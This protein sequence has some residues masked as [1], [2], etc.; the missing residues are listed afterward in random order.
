MI[1]APGADPDSLG[2]DKVTGRITIIEDHD[3]TH[4]GLGTRPVTLDSTM[5]VSLRGTVS[6]G[7]PQKSF[8]VELRDAVG[9]E[10]KLPVLGMPQEADWALVACWTDKPCMR[11]LLAYEM[12]RA[13]GRWAPRS[14]LVEVYFNDAYQGLYQLTESVRR[15]NDRVDIPKPAA[16]ESGGALLTGGYVFR[17]EATGKA[18][19]MASVARDWLSPVTAPGM[20]PH[21]IL[22]S[23]AIPRDSLIT[24]A[25]KRYLEG[26]VAEFE[27]MMKGPDWADPAS[28]YRSWIDVASWS[29]FLI[30]N[31][32][33]NNVDGLWKSMYVTKLRDENGARGKLVQ[34]PLWD[35]NIAFGNADYRNGWRV[36]RLL[37]T[38]LAS[39][40]G[41]CPDAAWLP[42]GAPLCDAY[43]CTAMCQ[44]PARCWNLPY[45]TF[46][47]E[48]LVADRTFRDE[49]RCRYR[50]MR[51][52]GG[53]LDLARINAWIDAWTAQIGPNAIARHL[54][55]WP[56]L[57][58][59]VW[60]NPY[61]LD[62]ATAPVAMASD[63]A[64]FDK[65]VQ[66]LR[67]WVGQR[68]AW[69]D[70]NLPGTCAAGDL[71][72]VDAG[73]PSQGPRPMPG[74]V[75]LK[76]GLVGYWKLNDGTGTT[77]KDSSPTRANGT[78]VG[79][80]DSD[81]IVAHNATG[82]A[83]DPLRRT[84]ITVPDSPALNPITGLSVGAWIKPVDWFG[85]RRIVQKGAADNQF[86]LLAEGGI[87]K[88]S[89]AGVKNGLVTAWNPGPGAWHH[90]LGTYDGKTI[91]LYVDGAV[92]AEE[93]ATGGNINTTT[94]NLII[95]HKSLTSGEGDG[96]SGVMD[97]VVLY[98]RGLNQ[99]EATEL[100][101]GTL[102]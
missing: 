70:Q 87:F 10:R 39:A 57:K 79:F 77:A 8:S 56:Q 18:P 84:A 93:E 36:D 7:F 69:L 101:K 29:D 27:E 25:Q 13:P 60:P 14:R 20:W 30:I 80:T 44:G 3:G 91:R 4:Q 92:V 50:S 89:L 12:G 97:E 65:E 72:R 71:P 17:R 58:G 21:Q 81:W 55:R 2:D 63:S 48:K 19:P 74:P 51:A 98:N 94:D 22:Y 73:A 1:T 31:E 23:Y 85:N 9:G 11:N 54:G 16:D 83:F 6:R 76:N 45:L 78:M 15:G 64:F 49:T 24:P 75:D 95:G 34:A 28:G 5:G 86:R 26:Y 61:N 66:W 68:L 100:A 82:L 41:E 59:Y 96:Y 42:R 32:A 90:V 35:F 43:C 67:D 52:A 38:T 88:F 47:W 37:A 53:A 46:W 62:P 102:P 40:G 33:S 99:S